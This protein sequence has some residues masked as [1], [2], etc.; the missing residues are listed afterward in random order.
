MYCVTLISLTAG[1]YTSTLQFNSSTGSGTKLDFYYDVSASGHLTVCA[2]VT[3]QSIAFKFFG[4]CLFC[5]TV[6]TGIEWLNFTESYSEKVVANASVTGKGHEAFNAGDLGGP[7]RSLASFNL[8]NE[9][10]CCGPIPIVYLNLNLN[11]AA[12]YEFTFDQGSWLNLSQGSAGTYSQNYTFQGQP[13]CTTT[14]GWCDSHHTTC[15]NGA[16]LSSLCTW[17]NHSKSFGGSV[18]LRVGPELVLTLSAGVNTGIFDLELASVTLWLF[19]YGQASLYFGVGSSTSVYTGCGNTGGSCKQANQGGTGGSCGTGPANLPYQVWGLNPDP[20]YPFGVK[21]DPAANNFWGVLCAGV[22]LQFGGSFKVFTFTL[23]NPL[24]S[25][26]IGP[27]NIF[28]WTLWKGKL[29]SSLTWYIYNGTLA[30]SIDVCDVTQKNCTGTFMNTLAADNGTQA[31]PGPWEMKFGEKDVLVVD[32]ALHSDIPGGEETFSLPGL[33]SQ[34][35]YEKTGWVYPVGATGPC[36]NLTPRAV[37]IPTLPDDRGPWNV[38]N[39]TAPYQVPDGSSATYA[40]CALW[41]NT[42]SPISVPNFQISNVTIWIRVVPAPGPEYPLTFVPSCSP[43][44]CNYL[45]YTSGV[46]SVSVTPKSGGMSEAETSLSDYA[47]F[48]QNLTIPRLPNGDYSYKITPPGNVTVKPLTGSFTIDYTGVV[49]STTFEPLQIKINEHGL[50]AGTTWAATVDGRT[51]TASGSW[52]D[53][54]T[55]AGKYSYTISPVTGCSITSGGK[56]TVTLT[57]KSATR[58]VTFSC[59]TE[60]SDGAA[61]APPAV[62]Y[63]VQFDESGLPTSDDAWYAF[64]APGLVW[65]GTQTFFQLSLPN[66]TYTLVAGGPAGYRWTQSIASGPATFSV[67]GASLVVDVVFVPFTY[68]VTLSEIGLPGGTLWSATFSH[69]STVQSFSTTSNNI[70]I[71]LTNGTG[72]KPYY[73]YAIG[74]IPGFEVVNATWTGGFNVAGANVS[75]VVELA[76]VTYVVTFVEYGLAPGTVFEV[77]FNGAVHDETVSTLNMSTPDSF[78]DVPNGTYQ[79]VIGSVAGYSASTLVGFVT[80]EGGT[81]PIDIYFTSATTYVVT[82]HETGLPSGA[83]WTAG[84]YDPIFGGNQSSTTDDISF[85]LT[86]GYYAYFANTTNSEYTSAPTGLGLFEVLSSALTIPI[87]FN[88]TN[89]SSGSSDRGIPHAQASGSAPAGAASAPDA[90]SLGSGAQAVVRSVPVREPGPKSPKP[91][92]WAEGSRKLTPTRIGQ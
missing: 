92:R 62:T 13:S 64:V 31:N 6:P 23:E 90:R 74:P 3:T 81:E 39:Y 45:D 79:F 21:G 77:N 71:E 54:N 72:A 49:I 86:P 69:S 52:L 20:M 36:G 42:G 44:V 28:T 40:I 68:A 65:S 29:F 91:C 10:I 47:P 89:S 9:A 84:A 53:F 16:A 25:I 33:A 51:L 63:P 73:T 17:L 18:L 83:K 32:T 70:T 2:G 14:S 50:S 56:G 11:I 87:H 60:S 22:G 59:G 55:T 57:T 67:D 7:P 30:T 48:N 66:G 78:D 35:W 27:P 24:H 12:E 26:G 41:F 76:P 37:P 75:L 85:D 46:W 43:E 4:S 58:K 19:L 34:T 88:Y 5:I 61:P 8:V 1:P 82:F 38:F 15:T 80:V